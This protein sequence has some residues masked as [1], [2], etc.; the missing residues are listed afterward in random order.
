MLSTSLIRRRVITE[1][2]VIL[3]E[4]GK[5]V[6]MVQ[7]NAT[8]NE[9]KKAVKEMYKVDPV[10]VATIRQKD[11]RRRYRGRV[12]YKQRDKKAIVTLKPGQ[13]IEAQ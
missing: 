13:K 12:S 7:P 5:Y 3:A 8:K 2:A 11:R 1:K 6:F 4:S 10:A 9:I